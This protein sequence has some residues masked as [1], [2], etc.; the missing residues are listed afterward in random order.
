MIKVT[1]FNE[2][3]HET[4]DADIKAVYPKGIHV[5]LSDFL[6]EQGFKVRTFTQHDDEGNLKDDIGITEEV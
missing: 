2:Y 5:V 3:L 4:T 1:I 6:E